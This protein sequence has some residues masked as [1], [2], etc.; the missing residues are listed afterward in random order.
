MSWLD[1][2][3]NINEEVRKAYELNRK[4]ELIELAVLGIELSPLE[5]RVYEWGRD[6]WKQLIALLDEN[7]TE[8]TIRD[9]MIENKCEDLP[10]DWVVN[11]ISLSR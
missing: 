2:G 10:I 8:E 7:I 4:S 1:A 9:Y 6:N 3:K 11:L 5:R